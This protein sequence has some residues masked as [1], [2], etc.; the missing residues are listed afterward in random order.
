MS[1]LAMSQCP[2]ILSFN[3]VSTPT[4]MMDST[5]KWDQYC[6]KP[7]PSFNSHWQKWQCKGQRIVKGLQSKQ[8]KG[9]KQTRRDT[10]THMDT[11]KGDK[12]I[13]IYVAIQWHGSWW[14][15][16]RW[17]PNSAGL[18]LCSLCV[19]TVCTHS[20]VSSSSHLSWLQMAAVPPW[21]AALWL[22]QTFRCVCVFARCCLCGWYDRLAKRLNYAPAANS[23]NEYADTDTHTHT[24]THTLVTY[25]RS[26]PFQLFRCVLI[27]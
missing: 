18:R 7:E 24:H 17:H 26:Y 21:D 12:T 2:Q 5:T 6:N 14:Q 22:W 9:K 25:K 4:G 20:S 15:P 23:P 27:P 3:F 11:H 1:F 19:C 10:H 16:L 13:Q 8:S